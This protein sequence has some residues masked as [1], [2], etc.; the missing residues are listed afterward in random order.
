MVTSTFRNTLIKK[1]TVLQDFALHQLGDVP[2]K[3][4]E[5]ALRA[6]QHSQFDR[7]KKYLWETRHDKA[8]HEYSVFAI[9]EAGR[10]KSEREQLASDMRNRWETVIAVW[11]SQDSLG[12][13]KD[14]AYSKFVSLYPFRIRTDFVYKER[15]ATPQK[16]GTRNRQAVYQESDTVPITSIYVP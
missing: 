12:M 4:L 7:T 13:D 8:S 9:F 6:S 1:K 3:Q 2:L 16:R 11:A 15:T 14:E 10:S 5:E